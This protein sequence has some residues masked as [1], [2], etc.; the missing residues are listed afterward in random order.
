M[1]TI[2]KNHENVKNSI[3]DNGVSFY[4]ELLGDYDQMIDWESRLQRETP[5]FNELFS[6]YDI[7]NLLDIGCGSG[8]H[9]FHFM[10]LGIESVIGVDPSSKF[11]EKA[12]ARALASGEEISFIEADFANI[13]E[14]VSDRF[15][16]VCC[17]GNSI[18]HVLIYD[19]LVLTLKNFAK[20]AADDGVVLVH[21]L[22]WHLRLA[23]AQ[24]FIPPASHKTSDS[25][26]LF[27][28]FFDYGDELV[29]MNLAIFSR[30]SSSIGKWYSRILSTTLRP[31]RWDILQMAAKDAGLTIKE[32]YGGTDL[33]P[34]QPEQSHDYI[35]TARN[36]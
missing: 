33:S 36:V 15:D 16:M 12:K 4:E 28:R 25:E 6:K 22:N 2:M 18:S 34:Y 3:P 29:T 31:W 24:R 8:R 5:F 21:C 19:D 13:I 10:T 23:N 7:K 1:R 35:F 20:L 17:L 9:A 27:F 26:K 11:I 14:R 32:E 30:D